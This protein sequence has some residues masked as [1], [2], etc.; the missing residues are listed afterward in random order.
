MSRPGKFAKSSRVKQLRQ[1]KR[2]KQQQAGNVIAWDRVTD[3]LLG[4]YQL[5][6]GRKLP[7]TVAATVQRF[8]SEWLTTAQAAGPTQLQWSVSELTTATLARIGN[9]VP[10]QFYAVLAG[11]FGSWQRFIRREGPAVP[12]EP[13]RQ[14]VAL[15]TP[16]TFNRALAH[17][18]AVNLLTVTAAPI[19]PAQEDQ[20]VHSLLDED[21]LNWAAVGALFTP[22]GFQNTAEKRSDTYQWLNDLQMLTVSDFHH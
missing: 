4:R 13:R 16:A 3:F 2:R 8:F 22:L 17:Q 6:Q 20:L 15:M 14:I 10:W 18:L 11:Q 21:Q 1:F 9:Q 5:T 7:A 19:T 12:I